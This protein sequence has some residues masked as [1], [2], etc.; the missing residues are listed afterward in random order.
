MTSTMKTVNNYFLIEE[1]KFKLPPFLTHH[2]QGE[3]GEPG[4]TIAADGSIISAPRGLQGPKGFKVP[5]TWASLPFGQAALKQQNM[6]DLQLYTLAKTA[7][8]THIFQ[9]DKIG[10][11]SL[12]RCKYW[13]GIT[14][15]AAVTSLYF[16]CAPQKKETQWY[17]YWGELTVG[18]TILFFLPFLFFYFLNKL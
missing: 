4:V 11:W 8:V 6:Q 3:K 16:Y 17:R 18:F 12:L 13:Q 10:S 1:I 9:S 5:D 7:D 15:S 14:V 2:W